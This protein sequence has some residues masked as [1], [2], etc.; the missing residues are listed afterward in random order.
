MQ[1]TGAPNG[2]APLAVG[3]PSRFARRRPVIAV[4]GRLRERRMNVNPSILEKIQTYHDKYRH[5]RLARPAIS[6]PY[7]LFPEDLA[8]AH[9]RYKWPDTWPHNE[10]PGV[11]LIFGADMKLLYVG[12]AT[13]IGSRLGAYFQYEKDTRGCRIAHAT[14]KTRPMFVVT[15]ALEKA[16]EANALEAYLIAELQPPENIQGVGKT[17]DQL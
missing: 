9:A 14:W 16:F 7:A 4:V 15:V 11:Y 5:P 2:V 1:S 3:F 6:E 8:S 10:S 12:K 13:R 17:I